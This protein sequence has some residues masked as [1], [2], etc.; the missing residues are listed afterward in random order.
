MRSMHTA[1]MHTMIDTTAAVVYTTIL[2][3]YLSFSE[4]ALRLKTKSVQHITSL[5]PRIPQPQVVMIHRAHHL[6]GRAQHPCTV[7][8]NMYQW[9]K[10]ADKGKKKKVCAASCAALVSL[11]ER[12]TSYYRGQPPRAKLAEPP[13]L[14][15]SQDQGIAVVG[16]VKRNTASHRDLICWR[17]GDSFARDCVAVYQRLLSF[18]NRQGEIVPGIADGHSPHVGVCPCRVEGLFLQATEPTLAMFSMGVAPFTNS[19]EETGQRYSLI[20]TA[21]ITRQLV[22]SAS[23]HQGIVPTGVCLFVYTPS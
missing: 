9:E 13:R 11:T 17:P 15:F 21:V 4:T 8:K 10:Q 6:P 12:Y 14:C 18:T 2:S 23:I 19:S 5:A 7:Q 22:V 20:L 1:V 16:V 3:T